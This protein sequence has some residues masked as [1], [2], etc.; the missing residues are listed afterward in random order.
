MKRMTAE[1]FFLAVAI[2]LAAIYLLIFPAWS[3]PDAGPHFSASYRYAN[4]MT[5][6]AETK[7]RAE[8]IRVFN[9][10]E[11]DNPAASDWARIRENFRWTVSDEGEAE[12][13]YP[14][15]IEKMKWYSILNYLPQAVGIAIGRTT[16]LGG[17]PTLYLARILAAAAYLAM[18]WR[19]IRITPSGKYVFAMIPMLPMWMMLGTSF[20]Y[21]V[22]VLGTAM[23]LTASLLR[24][25]S[26]ETG[27]KAVIEAAVWTILTAGVKGGCNLLL[28]GMLICLPV[29]RVRHGGR[30]ALGIAGIGAAALVLF[31]VILPGGSNF[32]MGA[33]DTGN[34]YAGW[35][36][37]H[38]GEYI[39]MVIRTYAV[40]GIGI[41]MNT[42]GTYL[43]WI[44]K[45]IPHGVILAWM[46]MIA[47]VGIWEKDTFRING[48]DRWILAGIL[49]CSLIG[50]PAM[51]LS[52]TPRGAETVEG[53]QGRYYCFLMPIFYLVA[54]KWGRSCPEGRTDP[55]ERKDREEPEGRKGQTVMTRIACAGAVGMSA[56]CL[57][58]MLG[59][60]CHR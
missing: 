1:R 20:S 60:Y 57:A 8:D 32:Q 5:G 22:M 4:L 40:N 59:L 7:G 45:T 30:I 25:R 49:I 29:N 37:S 48:K 13:P 52:Y 6:R 58:I 28:L 51:M 17:V 44:E 23:G 36:L 46:A 53:L 15:M 54:T 21:D 11:N 3:V 34:Y 38:F 2:P 19:S 16:G 27:K 24:F 43:G 14:E 56:V 35:A 41:A 18:G 55:A 39:G 42:G 26:G 33:A 47:I 31:D 10:H 50:I 9:D 12:L